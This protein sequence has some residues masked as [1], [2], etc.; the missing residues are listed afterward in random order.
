MKFQADILGVKTLRPSVVE[1]TALGAAY[2]A[3]L[4]IGYWK[5]RDEIE[6]NWKC[7]KTFT[8]KMKKRFNLDGAYNY[9]SQIKKNKKGNPQQRA[10]N[11]GIKI[12]LVLSLLYS[13]T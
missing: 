4:A 7:S 12:H 13:F 2:L 8:P 5:D 6:K 3:G 1:T 9:W 10:F 11:K